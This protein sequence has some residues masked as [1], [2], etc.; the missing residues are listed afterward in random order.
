MIKVSCRWNFYIY[1]G[2][3]KN[4]YLPS[5]FFYI[6]LFS[7][8]ISKKVTCD[9]QSLILFI[10]CSKIVPFRT[11]FHLL[12]LCLQEAPICNTYRRFNSL[13]LNPIQLLWCCYMNIYCSELANNIKFS[14]PTFLIYTIHQNILS[15][16]LFW[17]V[18]PTMN[19]LQNFSFIQDQKDSLNFYQW[20]AWFIL[21]MHYM[22]Q[23][24]LTFYSS[25]Q[26]FHLCVAELI[27]LNIYSYLLL[28]KGF[29]LFLLS[30]TPN[31]LTYQVKKMEVSIRE[32]INKLNDI[33][34][35]R[36]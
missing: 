10:L 34:P 9:L 16:Y 33:P 4:L 24:N 15:E 32:K 23:P 21:C 7:L 25:L 35:Y 1:F 3:L 26:I 18:K 11:A 31:F 5:I 2:I 6:K 29:M 8:E 27:T 28:K 17:H 19:G 12:N 13:R 22:T 30:L 36:L 20:P 14:V